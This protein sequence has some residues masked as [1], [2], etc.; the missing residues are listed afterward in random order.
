MGMV[1]S[2]HI[3]AH[4]VTPSI[5]VLGTREFLSEILKESGVE[6]K[7]RHDS[8]HQQNTLSLEY[9]KEDGLAFI[10]YLYKDSAIY[11]NRK[12]LFDFFKN[13]SRSVK[14]FTELLSGNIGGASEMG[15]TEINSDTKKSESS[16]SVDS[17]TL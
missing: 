7:F 11:L 2:R 13:G 8:R 6:A 14:E 3:S 16:Y 5:S 17:E 9:N 12:K 1:F 10:N 15:N 4:T